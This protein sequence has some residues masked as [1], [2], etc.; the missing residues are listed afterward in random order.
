[1][2]GGHK[3]NFDG[4]SK[5]S[6]H[7]LHIFPQV[8]GVKCI[9]EETEGESIGT[10]G[11]YGLPPRGYAEGYTNNVCVLPTAGAPYMVSGGKLSDPTTVQAS[12]MLGNNT[13]YAPSGD[14]S[15]T[16][17]GE[18]VSFTQFQAAGFDASSSASAEM[19]TNNQI[20]GWAR[21]LLWGAR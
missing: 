15:V 11:P 18:T 16:M 7:N 21:P 5:V 2:Y 1:V 19:P 8:Y 4:H 10:A 20:I 12:L 6:S 13:I 9:D 17:G 14:V 3:Q